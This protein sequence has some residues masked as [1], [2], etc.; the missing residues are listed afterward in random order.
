MVL[1][2]TAAC[3]SVA[4]VNFSRDILPILSDACFLC[5]GPDE[6][7]RESEL[8]FD[9]EHNVKSDR[10]G[11]K[12]VDPGN[13]EASELIRRITSEEQCEVMPPQELE[14]PPVPAG[15]RPVD[16]FIDLRLAELACE[17]PPRAD[18]RKYLI[19]GKPASI[20]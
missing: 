18:S 7:S 1:V 20:A 8:R 4:E 10:G 5:H 15:V 11:C 17:P 3:D 6:N 19:S 13:S 9:D 2:G 14:R 16:Y 12:V